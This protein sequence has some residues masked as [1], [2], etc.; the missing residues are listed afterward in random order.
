MGYV[1]DKACSTAKVEPLHYEELKEQYILDTKVV[2]EMEDVPLDLIMNWDHTGINI[3]PGCPW[4]IEEKGAKSVD[5]VRL[6]DKR[7]IT[8]VICATI[9][10][11]FLPFQVI[12]EG[13]RAA[14]LPR[15]SFPE[16]WNVTYTPN[17]WSNET[18]SI[19]LRQYCLML[20]ENGVS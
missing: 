6:D 12:Y 16:K 19:L 20:K 9:S 7:Q 11:I 4:T 10:G 2:V 13:K 17:H 18:W 14:S 15:Y 1:K 5:C 8:T 3:V